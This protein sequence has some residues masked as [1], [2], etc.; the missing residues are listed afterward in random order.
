M[1]VTKF[2]SLTKRGIHIQA[3]LLS[4]VKTLDGDKVAMEHN[5]IKRFS[6]FVTE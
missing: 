1:V 4:E 5:H 2:E 3:K 6:G